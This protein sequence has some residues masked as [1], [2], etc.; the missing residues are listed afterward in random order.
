[1]R[2][3]ST[4][5]S[6]TTTA[7]ASDTA[8]APAR[9]EGALDRRL[10]QGPRLYFNVTAAPSPRAAVALLHGFAEYGARYA[11][12]ADFWAARGLTTIAIDM[13][14]HGRAEGPRGYCDRFGEYLDDM[15]ELVELVRLRAPDLPAFIYGHS[16]GGLVATTHVLRSPGR[17][18]GLLLTG[19]NFGIAVK[20]PWVKQAA[21]KVMSQLVPNFGLPSGLH[22]SDLTHDAARAKAYEEDPLVFNKARAR[23]YTET[24]QAQEKA[25]ERAPSLSLPLYIAMGTVDRVSDFS[26]A[27]TFFQNAGSSDKTFDARE[28]LFHEVLNEPEWRDIAGPMADW[29][30][31]RI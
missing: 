27:R 17:W 22:G 31:A 25:M 3:A 14:G 20:V 9:E 26:T 18:R 23:W 29:M 28:G 11:H 2:I 1:M 7:P 12:V 10:T 21:G 13:R 4:T 15:S 24:L 6:S 5:M 8:G 19:P 30:L 16:F